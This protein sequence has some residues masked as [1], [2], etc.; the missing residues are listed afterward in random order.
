M[1]A[2]GGQKVQLQTQ[3]RKTIV[4]RKGGFPLRASAD[5]TTSAPRSARALAGFSLVELLVVIAIMGVLISLLL[6]AVQAAR[7]SARRLQCTNNIRQLAL[8]TQNYESSYG[9]LPPSATLDP[10]DKT[11][12]SGDVNVAYPVADHEIGK[13]YSW[14]VI[15]LPFLEQKNLYDRFDFSRS[16]FDQ[17][18]E[19]QSHTISSYLCPSDEARDRY[20]VDEELTQGKRFAKGNYAA[21]VSPFHI[22]LQ[23]LYPGALISAGQSLKHVVDGTS[24]TIAFSEVRTLDH[25]QDERGAWALPWAGASLLSFDMHHQCAAGTYPCPEDRK[26]R[27]NPSS[28]GFTQTPNVDEGPV[29]DT[30]HRCD[31]GSDQENMSDLQRMPCTRWRW[32]IGLNGYY[33]ASPRSRH[34]GGVN[35][36]YLDGH[37]SFVL[38][39]VDEYSFAYRVSINDGQAVD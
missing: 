24:N 27:A 16:L 29:K 13:P 7:E 32:T 33:S 9:R 11:I 10:R 5:L 12:R 15:L 22:D 20:F 18:S 35:A 37:A 25:P 28:E 39:D 19:A 30:I 31:S 14:A 23:L 36:A 1:Q 6:P 26:Y 34:P 2:R 4:K 17:E 8:A 3:F 38:D 21:F